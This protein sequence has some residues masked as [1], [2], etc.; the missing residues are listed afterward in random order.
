LPPAAG[1]CYTDSCDDPSGVRLDEAPD[2][3][4]PRATDARGDLRAPLVIVAMTVWR[5]NAGGPLLAAVAAAMLAGAYAFEHLGGL[6]PCEL[7]WWQRYAW[8]ATLALALAARGVGTERLGGLLLT[9]AG[10]AGLAGAGIAFFHVGV[11]QHWWQGTAA[12][13]GA[14]G[15]AL[16][17]E[18]RLRQLLATPVVRCDEIAW[19]MFGLSMAAW[20]GVI[21]LGAGGVAAMLGL[22]QLCAR[23]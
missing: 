20:N 16:S 13:G 23:S 7:C 3:R 12:C 15:G 18:E 8:M 11:E 6:R 9:L 5:R 19:S 1:G 22:R 2:A 17:V 14:A 4:P 10:G 21:A